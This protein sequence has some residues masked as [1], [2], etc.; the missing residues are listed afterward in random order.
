[1]DEVV[2]ISVPLKERYREAPAGPKRCLKLS[3][4]DGI[5]H[6]FGMEYRPIKDLTVLAPAGLKIIVRNVHTRRGLLMLVP[7]AVEILG[8]VVDELE[9]ARAR[10]VS[11]VNKPPRG[12]SKQGGLSLSSR[13]TRAA[14]PCS[15][16][17]TNGVAQGISM[18]RAVNSSYPTGSGNAFQVGGATETVVEE[19]VSPLVA[20]RV[21]EINMQGSYAS[22][23][24]E[25]TETSMHTTHEYDPTHITEKS[26]GTVM[27]E[28]PDPPILANSVHEQ[29]QRVQPA[30]GAQSSNVG[31]INQMEQSFILSGENEKP[32]TY[33]Y[34]MLIDW[35]RQQDTKAYIQGKIKGLIT[36]V[37]K[38][39]YKQR[40][41]YELYVYIDDGSFISEA[42][43][44]SDIVNNMLGLSP[45]EV[46]AALAGELEFASPSEVKETL[47]GFQKFLVK[48]E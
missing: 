25:T 15:T 9:A 30:N 26:T 47:K 36:S 17:I 40:T 10:L 22:L 38:F 16:D 4:T 13:A 35:G 33:I 37:K 14:W 1:V 44:D 6:I 42:F 24:R 3:M 11:E 18:Q 41:K 5:R 19:L 23:T 12:K 27:E 7:E 34:S 31:K 29:M 2:N 48:F 21:Q 20:N 8:G 32:F 28:R 39:Q 45:G 46:T 43:I